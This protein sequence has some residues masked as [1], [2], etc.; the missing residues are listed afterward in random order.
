MQLKIAICDDDIKDCSIIHHHLEH[1]GIQF[2]ID[3]QIREYTS[4]EQLL[5]D[6][7]KSYPFHI[8]FLDVE[9][10][11]MNGLELAKHI[12]QHKDKQVIIV[13]ISNYPR[14]MQDSF[15]V[16]PFHYLT[17]PVN[18]QEFQK[19]M[20]QIVQ[21]FETST[22]HKVVIHEDKQ[23]ELVNINDLLYI[24][25]QNGKKGQLSFVLSDKTLQ[26]KGVLI[27]WEKELSPHHFILCHRGILVNINH[28]HY[29]KER[30]VVL[31]NGIILP[32]SRR[33][34]KELR[35]LFSKHILTLHS[36]I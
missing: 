25:A 11:I 16:H 26:S 31:K 33:K 3:Y 9:M 24:E 32:L 5:L 21:E 36:N 14:Y 23:E 20:S 22:I 27:D 6:Y 34:E 30:N 19:V 8:L 15:E 17:K 12:R 4:A 28:I 35:M 1:Y 13:F 18:E 29:I 7:N 10:P 2:D